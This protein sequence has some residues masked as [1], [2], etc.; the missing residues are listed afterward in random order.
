MG[1]MARAFRIFTI[2]LIPTVL[3]VVAGTKP[4]LAKV[5]PTPGVEV[6]HEQ[7]VIF[8]ADRGFANVNLVVQD[9]V[10]VVNKGRVD[11]PTVVIPL[12]QGAQGLKIEE[13]PGQGQFIEEEQA[14]VDKRPLKAGE[15]RRY[16]FN[17]GLGFPALPNVIA[18]PLLY[19]V[20]DMTVAV[21][22]GL[23]SIKAPGL[24][25][26]GTVLM[27]QVEIRR[28]ASTKPLAADPEFSFTIDKGER[29]MSP[30]LWAWVALFIL[31]LAGLVAI[32][33]RSAR[34][35]GGLRAGPRSQGLAGRMGQ[36]HP[37][38]HSRPGGT[39]GASRAGASGGERHGPGGGRSSGGRQRRD[40][41]GR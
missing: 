15:T 39:A 30:W 11:Q 38:H 33:V 23:F 40:T 26:K 5:A 6:S 7:I 12:A 4:G 3:V 25:D 8:E 37:E 20:A 17:Y 14:F 31:P 18:R 16:S 9:V 19:P 27:G 21:P 41:K 2:I 22:A 29:K 36:P 13:G 24:A 34:L 35:K 28:Y 32:K 10:E 1:V